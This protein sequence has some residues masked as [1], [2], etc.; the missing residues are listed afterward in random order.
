MRSRAHPMTKRKLRADLRGCSS[1]QAL[2][3]AGVRSALRLYK[4][5]L[6]LGFSDEDG[7]EQFHVKSL[8]LKA[9]RLH[10]PLNIPLHKGRLGNR[11]PTELTSSAAEGQQKRITKCFEEKV[12]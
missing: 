3:V 7:V 11:R 1:H 5:A 8:G 10:P 9:V 2:Q 6:L 12:Y 4:A